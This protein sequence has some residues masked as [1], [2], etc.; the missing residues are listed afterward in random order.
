MKWLLANCDINAVAVLV[1][2]EVSSNKVLNTKWIVGAQFW[3]FLLRSRTLRSWRTD[4][5]AR[6][7]VRLAYKSYQMGIAFSQESLCLMDG[8][9]FISHK[10]KV[11]EMEEKWAEYSFSHYRL[12][13][14]GK[15][16]FLFQ[17]CL[18]ECSCGRKANLLCSFDK[19]KRCCKNL[20]EEC[21]AHKHK[22]S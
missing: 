2:V 12:K 11:E 10:K 7:L 18:S 6:T 9:L 17:K 19:F 14:K 22:I 21:K 13:A 5:P 4:S 8:E 15:K 16:L 1:K 20:R 3:E